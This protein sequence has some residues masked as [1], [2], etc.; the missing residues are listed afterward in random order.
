MSTDASATEVPTREGNRSR[1]RV[2]LA[3]YIGSVIEW[4][5]FYLYGAAAAVV[6]QPLFFPNLSPVLGLM[7]SFATL[8]GGFIARPI[9][10]L[11]WGHFGDRLGRKRMLVT[12]VLLMGTATTLVGV[13]PTFAQVGI[14]APILLVILRLVQGLSAGG[15]WAGAGLMALEHAR[16]HR[17]GLWSSVAQIGV[18]SGI[19]LSLFVFS[20]FSRLPEETFLSWGWRIPFLGAALLV[21]VGLYIRLK[22]EESPV[23]QEAQQRRGEDRASTSSIPL[24]ELLRN[25]W[26]KLLVGILL[27]IGPF[28]ANAVFITFG[29]SYATQVGYEESTA[30]TALTI[31]TVA[32]VIG[33]LL[34]AALSDYV[35]RKPVYAA[36][37]VLLG[38][39]S[40]LMFWLFD[41]ESV[42]WL[43]LAWIITYGT[44]SIMYGPLAAYL[45][46][47]F[48]TSTRYTGSS[49][50]YQLA[51]SL[52]GG[53]GPLVATALLALGGG[54]PNTLYVSL[55]MAAT[56]VASLL[57]VLVSRETYRSSISGA[58]QGSG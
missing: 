14:W 4:Y 1:L 15:E 42:L 12:S 38:I 7:A 10:G 41:T 56:C 54:P 32:S 5:D 20:L 22:V 43:Y 52:G 19:A 18:G 46:E 55:F 21:V 26:R 6:F 44:H 49:I 39:N 9:G 48:T 16:P 2:L 35:G 33:G 24:V 40:F 45:A 17:R 53:F 36:G 28:T 31:A 8:G 29:L 51:A 57:G 34:S 37:A 11:I 23:F 30:T 13:L 58:P 50:G 3:S 25:E 47:L 27:V